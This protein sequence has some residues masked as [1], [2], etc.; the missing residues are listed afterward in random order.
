MNQYCPDK[1]NNL[2]SVNN[3]QFSKNIFCYRENRSCAESGAYGHIGAHQSHSIF[4]PIITPY[5]TYKHKTV[6]INQLNDTYNHRSHK[7]YRVI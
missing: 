4:F 1:E 7:W 5:Y 3:G 2:S 6:N